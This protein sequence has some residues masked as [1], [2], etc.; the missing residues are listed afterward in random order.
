MAARDQLQGFAGVIQ[1]TGVSQGTDR[2]PRVAR[3]RRYAVGRPRARAPGALARCPGRP[4]QGR[5]QPAPCRKEGSSPFCHPDECMR[6]G[7]SF[8]L[9]T[10]SRLA[11]QVQI[12]HCVRNDT[13]EVGNGKGR[14]LRLFSRAWPAPTTARSEWAMPAIT[15]KN[16]CHRSAALTQPATS[17]PMSQP[18]F[19]SGRSHSKLRPS[20]YPRDL[21]LAHHRSRC[22]SERDHIRGWGTASLLTFFSLAIS[23]AFFRSADSASSPFCPAPARGV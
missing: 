19:G 9:T 21:L 20:G 14:S 13:G 5:L 10:T 11:C 2:M 12:P 15:A 18:R 16:H 17:M 3:Q 22:S 6:R 7:I 23:L 4:P 1:W 8:G